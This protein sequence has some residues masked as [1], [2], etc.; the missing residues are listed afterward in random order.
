[1]AG[2]WTE[3]G[4]LT[5]FLRYKKTMQ[6]KIKYKVFTKVFAKNNHSIYSSYSKVAEPL[7]NKGFVGVFA[8]FLYLKQ[9]E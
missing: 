8:C 7:V 2:M 6:N 9:K 5:G 3:S 4:L 1:M